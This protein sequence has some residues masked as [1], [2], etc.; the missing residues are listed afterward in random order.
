[1]RG[2][3]SL[4][5]LRIFLTILGS[6]AVLAGAS[7]LTLGAES[8]AGVEEASPAVDSEMRFYA[9]WYVA[10]G[11]LLIRA[12][13]RV[14]IES[15]FIRVVAAAFFIAGCVRG[16]SWVMVGRPPTI[17]VVLMVIELALPFVILPWQRRVARRARLP[18]V[19]E[20]ERVEK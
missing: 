12:V 8:I 1:M 15:T 19:S 5:G 18:S 17:A 13:P 14:E 9:V 7:T 2:D 3:R 16:L 6:V 20:S 11:V 10:A 4:R